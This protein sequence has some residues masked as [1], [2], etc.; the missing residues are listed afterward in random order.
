MVGG[1]RAGGILVSVD[2]GNT[3]PNELPG[4]QVVSDPRGIAWIYDAVPRTLAA[5][6]NGV[7][8][9]TDG[10]GDY[11]HLLYYGPPAATPIRPPPSS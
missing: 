2:G 3:G 11:E 8:S 5:P 7:I 4:A 6:T 1:P 10:N 9:V